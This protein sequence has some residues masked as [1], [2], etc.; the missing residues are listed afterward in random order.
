MSF[1]DNL[2]GAKGKQRELASAFNSSNATIG[3]TRTAQ[4]GAYKQANDAAI[5]NINA[6]YDTARNDIQGGITS[7][8]GAINT[9]YD[10]ARGDLA[11]N[12]GNAEGA[13]N[14]GMDRTRNLLNPLV[15]RGTQYNTMLADALGANG[16]AARSQFY[17]ANVG[18]NPEFNFADQLA[19]KQLQAKLNAS[20]ITGGRGAAL[21]LRQGAQRIEDRTNQYLDR[22]TGLAARGDQAATTLAG[23]EN[24][25][26][27]QI[28]GIRTGLGD[29]L[30]T[31]ETNRGQ[32]LG[33]FDMNGATL[34]SNNAVNRGGALAAANTAYG[35][36]VANAEGNYGQNTATN[37]IN[38]GNARSAL[39]GTGMNAMM[40][41]AGMAIQ[42]FT[43]GR[44]GSTPFSNFGNTVSRG[45]SSF[46][47]S[48]TMPAPGNPT[49][50][51]PRRPWAT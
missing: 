31:L 28:A 45:I 26:G 3:N 43:P 7:G 46:G 15:Q 40:Q 1:L 9:G 51:D 23:Y 20:G 37:A 36:N 35:Q 16:D 4:L 22:I 21:Q 39:Q 41:L 38:Y 30:G 18:N 12:Y 11:T 2:F 33:N 32:T 8:R 29:R 17:R 14:A 42:G 6:G 48:P 49:M 27:T 47:G 10:T 34:L 50:P 5:G 13:I 44:D 24:G 25:A 19:A